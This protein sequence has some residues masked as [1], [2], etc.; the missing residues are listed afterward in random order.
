MS[1]VLRTLREARPD[2]LAPDAPVDPEVRRAELARAMAGGPGGAAGRA[3]PLPRTA[4]RRW[5]PVW[6]L[7]LAGAAVAA[8]LVAVS[9]PAADDADPGAG[10]S[11]AGGP[12][13]TLD[14]G[15]VLLAAAAKT[16]AR[17]AGAGAFWRVA[18]V[19]T[20]YYE[21]GEPGAR[22]TI[23]VGSEHES[24]TPREPG[25]EVR[26]RQR[27]LG[28]RAA[29]P[30]DA[31]AWRRAGSPSA[32]SVEV[33]TTP[34]GGKLKPLRVTTAPGRVETSSSPLVDGDKVFWLGRN[35][36]MKDL[37]ALP[38]DP[39]ELKAELL[40][41][42][43]GHDTESSSRPMEADAWLFRTS[44]G[45]VTD[46]P[47][48]PRVRAAAFRMLA[49]LESVEGAGEVTDSRGRTGQGVAID[50]DTP[51]GTIRHRL[52]IDPASGRALA[53]EQVLLKPAAGVE[54]A[55]GTVLSSAAVTAMEWTDSAPR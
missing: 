47:V 24:W 17:P 52:V 23:A 39:A 35:V 27:E 51:L 36:T 31:A 44:V 43:E 3:V 53:D 33:P 55:A 5:R 29:T 40:R 49:G 42:Y 15:T 9:L 14:A 6:G 12:V 18:K 26:S 28:A 50:E 48:E 4:A 20:R 21:V 1:D 41:W 32:F 8:A 19:D 16:E 30:A 34:G 25:G 45:L 54:R 10:T 2:E 11:V 22:Y 38:A 37:R 13:R 7:G 46:M